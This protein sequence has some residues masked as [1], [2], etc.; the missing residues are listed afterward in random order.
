ML[1]IAYTIIVGQG[2]IHSKSRGN[3]CCDVYCEKVMA[4]V[5]DHGTKILL[6]DNSAPNIIG[7]F[8]TLTSW[9]IS[10]PHNSLYDFQFLGISNNIV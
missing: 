6:L 4:V 8:I 9:S 1:E 7:L 3:V 10:L 2:Q 5:L